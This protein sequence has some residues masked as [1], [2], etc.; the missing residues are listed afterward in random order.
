MMSEEDGAIIEVCAM[1][2]IFADGIDNIVVVNGV[3]HCVLYALQPAP[4]SHEL[5]KVAVGRIAMPMTQVPVA[6]G[7]A[8]TAVAVEAVASP[9]SFIRSGAATLS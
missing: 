7:K 8:I 1:Q 6:A 4:I 3:F 2:E 9:R 5:I